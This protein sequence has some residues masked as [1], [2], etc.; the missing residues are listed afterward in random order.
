MNPMEDESATDA[1]MKSTSRAEFNRGQSLTKAQSRVLV[2]QL[3]T[4]GILSRASPPSTM[5]AENEMRAPPGQPAITR[6]DL[7][8]V[9]DNIYIR[10]IPMPWIW[11]MMYG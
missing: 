1:K 9:G 4:H 6:T 2:T 7:R 8:V 10:L 5:P 11:A 3:L